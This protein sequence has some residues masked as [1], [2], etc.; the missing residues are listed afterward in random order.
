MSFHIKQ[1]LLELNDNNPE[2]SSVA[3]WEPSAFGAYKEDAMWQ[4]KCPRNY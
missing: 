4:L 3:D 2:L 1:G